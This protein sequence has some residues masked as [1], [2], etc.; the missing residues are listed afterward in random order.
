[1]CVRILSVLLHAVDFIANA[2]WMH[3]IMHDYPFMHVHVDRL[4]KAR[5]HHVDSI[6]TLLPLKQLGY[7]RYAYE[8]V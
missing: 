1:M 3:L 8:I 5:P 6:K 4:L 2:K 7:L